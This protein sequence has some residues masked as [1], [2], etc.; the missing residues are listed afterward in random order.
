M[1]LGIAANKKASHMSSSLWHSV[2][3]WVVLMASVAGAL[4][5][6]CK[7]STSFAHALQVLTRQGARSETALHED[8]TPPCSPLRTAHHRS[9]AAAGDWA[10]SHAGWAGDPSAQRRHH[11]TGRSFDD[12]KQSFDSLDADV[13]D[14]KQQLC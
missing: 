3:Q 1:L 11:P 5:T 4:A 10:L 8:V 14:L 13:A 6:C 7:A 12:F 9:K 2:C